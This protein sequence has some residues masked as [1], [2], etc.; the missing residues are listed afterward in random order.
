MSLNMLEIIF[1][2]CISSWLGRGSSTLMFA[3]EPVM[4]PSSFLFKMKRGSC[5]KIVVFS[6]SFCV[7][8]RCPQFWVS[9]SWAN[10]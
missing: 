7:D 3:G 10:L 4:R 5:C 9:A 2:V 6:F 8:V 1:L